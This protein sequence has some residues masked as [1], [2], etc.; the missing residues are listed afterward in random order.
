[1]F[2]WD[3]FVEVVGWCASREIVVVVFPA[4]DFGEPEEL[5]VFASG[6]PSNC[7]SC[8]LSVPMVVV[9]FFFTCTTWPFDWSFSREGKLFHAVDIFT[10]I[11]IVASSGTDL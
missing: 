10:R 1:M 2:V 9:P 4:Q 11:G 3:V 7:A 5:H 6:N 8:S